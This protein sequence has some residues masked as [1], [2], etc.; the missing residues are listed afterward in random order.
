MA[1]DRTR[2]R[3]AGGRWSVLPSEAAHLLRSLPPHGSGFI[4]VSMVATAGI[5]CFPAREQR[6]SWCH[7]NPLRRF[8]RGSTPTASPPVSSRALMEAGP[9]AT[10]VSP[11]AIVNALTVSGSTVYA[12]TA[13][14]CFRA[15]AVKDGRWRTRGWRLLSRPQSRPIPRIRQSCSR[16]HST[17]CSRR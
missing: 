2:G 5:S 17:A 7:H 11:R 1:P 9:G 12:A 10:P 16:Q 3:R 6:L 14:E 13:R 4:A 15:S 8:T